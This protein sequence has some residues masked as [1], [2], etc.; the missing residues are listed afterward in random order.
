MSAAYSGYYPWWSSKLSY[1]TAAAF[2]MLILAPVAGCWMCVSL[3]AIDVF[4]VGYSGATLYVK[5]E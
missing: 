2:M 4:D 3:G 1:I 5:N